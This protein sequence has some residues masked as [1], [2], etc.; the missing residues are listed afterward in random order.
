MENEQDV[1]DHY[2]KKKK[3]F[4]QLIKQPKFWSI[5]IVAIVGIYLIFQFFLTSARSLSTQELKA[6][7]EIVWHETSWVNKEVTPYGVTIVPS[8]TLK[9]KN[10]GT[11]PLKY[12][13]FIGIFLFEENEKQLSDGF[14]SVFRKPLEP[15][16]TSEEIF[17]K[18]F[19]GYKA[20][21]KESF[22]KNKTGW[23]KVKV[24]VFAGTS[25]TPALLGIFSVKQEIE[26][27]EA[28]DIS[29]SQ[30]EAS[31]KTYLTD[32]LRKSIQIVWNESYWIYQKYSQEGIIV[33]P[34]I[35]IKVKNTGTAPLRYISFRGDFQLVSS[36]KPFS[37]GI[38]IGLEDPLSPGKISDE[39][40]IPA[41][42]GYSVPSLEALEKN[43]TM[44]EK[45]KVRVTAKTKVSSEVLLGIFPV[46][47]I[48][49]AEM[50]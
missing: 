20:K 25:S 22:F 41:E 10:I 13:K 31:E 21:S 48:I 50:K 15:G 30:S 28:G 43:K 32:E 33:V 5:L 45:V 14:I 35:R 39:I 47:G 1:F 36:G 37:Q 17:I 26:G 38:T 23:K 6:S 2:L 4:S 24:K 29:E 12:V 40:R 27:L 7:I 11:K 49:K 34:F 44:M 19:N 9:I 42:Y 8:I 46:K 3:T 18:A 16:E